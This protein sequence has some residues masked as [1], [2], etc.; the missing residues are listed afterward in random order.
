M[1]N[2]QSRAAGTIPWHDTRWLVRAQ[3][4]NRG[5]HAIE[6]WLDRFG[7]DS[8]SLP[9]EGKETIRLRPLPILA[10]QNLIGESQAP[11][12]ETAD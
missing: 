9:V 10:C 6:Y 11:N 2:V 5:E 7:Q 3:Q 4:G 8:R 12:A 1:E